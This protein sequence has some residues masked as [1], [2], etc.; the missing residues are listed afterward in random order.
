MAATFVVVDAELKSTDELPAAFMPDKPRLVVSTVDFDRST[1]SEPLATWSAPS[2]PRPP[3]MKTDSDL[4]NV[5]FVFIPIAF[6][7]RSISA[8]T[9]WNS[10]FSTLR[11]PVKVSEADCVAS[12]L[13]RS[14][15]LPIF[16]IPPSI[17]CNVAIASLALRTPCVSTA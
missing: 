15:S 12:V 6:D 7:W 13:A 8:I 17:V 11:E 4:A 16:E 3:P 5:P 14:S 10:P 2:A 1:L 9:F